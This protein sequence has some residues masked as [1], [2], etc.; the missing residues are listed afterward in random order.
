MNPLRLQLQSLLFWFFCSTAACA[1]EQ[2]GV[3]H[4]SPDVNTDQHRAAHSN[5][6]Y[7]LLGSGTRNDLLVTILQQLK[8]FVRGRQEDAHEFLLVVLE[9]VERDIKRG[10]VELGGLKSQVTLIEELFMGRL[11]S[12]VVCGECGYCS[13]SY[14]QVTTLSLD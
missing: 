4:R 13:N 10:V 6:A 8:A 5:L 11:R 1:A 12:Q 3:S 9:A 7:V 2:P 14:E